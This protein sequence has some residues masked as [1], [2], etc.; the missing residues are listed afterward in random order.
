MPRTSLTRNEIYQILP[1]GKVISLLETAE[2]ISQKELTAT[3]GP[4]YPTKLIHDH[5]A[6]QFVVPGTYLTE[7]MS[8]AAG[9]LML[10][11]ENPTHRIPYLLSIQNMRFLSS[12]TDSQ[13]IHIHA[14][15]IGEVIGDMADYKVE[16]YIEDQRIAAGQLSLMLR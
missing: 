16:A 3:I 9:L 12:A 14:T 10:Q 7:A 6:N 5:F 8:Q 4:D 2:L 15:Q 13:I 11:G 1:H